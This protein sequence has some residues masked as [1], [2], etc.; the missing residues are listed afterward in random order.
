[1]PTNDTPSDTARINAFRA[2]LREP[3][4]ISIEGATSYWLETPREEVLGPESHTSRAPLARA[5]TEIQ[6]GRDPEG[7]RLACKLASGE[8]YVVVTG[9][10]LAELAGQSAGISTPR[11]RVAADAASA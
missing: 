7:L 6:G 4:G 10:I 9:S 8:R 11:R 5:L 1:M 2:A 3:I